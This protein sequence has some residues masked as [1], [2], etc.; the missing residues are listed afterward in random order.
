MIQTEVTNT[1]DTAGVVPTKRPLPPRL[2]FWWRKAFSMRAA[3]TSK[4]T[5]DTFLDGKSLST[6]EQT[7]IL[8]NITAD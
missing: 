8:S 7:D 5:I 6:D 1:A 4:A 3:G 2:G